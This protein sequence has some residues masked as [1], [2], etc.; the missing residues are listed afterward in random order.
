[1]GIERFAGREKQ[2]IVTCAIVSMTGRLI[3][4]TALEMRKSS[5]EK[6]RALAGASRRDHLRLR[7][8]ESCRVGDLPSATGY[9][10]AYILEWLPDVAWTA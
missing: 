6:V 10:W 7:I 1:M 5:L 4:V 3:P 9:A 8:V 2:C